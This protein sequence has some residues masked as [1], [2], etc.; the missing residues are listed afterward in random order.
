MIEKLAQL[1]GGGGGGAR[2]PHFT[3]STIKYKVVVHAPAERANTL[4]LL[5]LY[6]YK[7]S[8]SKKGK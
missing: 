8:A 2:P 4:P 6:P 5:L 1:G 3:I 7:Y